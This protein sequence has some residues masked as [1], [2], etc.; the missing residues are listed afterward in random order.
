MDANAGV[1]PPRSSTPAANGIFV[2]LAVAFLLC[3]ALI[4]VQINDLAGL[5][6][7]PLL[8]HIP[9]ILVPILAVAAVA[10]MLRPDWRLRYGLALAILA[11]ISLASTVLTVGAGEAFRRARESAVAGLSGRLPQGIPAPPGGGQSGLNLHAQLGVQLRVIMFVFV[12]VILAIV[13]ADA[14]R[15]R[16]DHQGRLGRFAALVERPGLNR[17]IR[18]AVAGLAVLAV[19]WVVRTGHEG[20]KL[21]WGNQPGF[22]G[23]SQQ[24]FPPGQQFPGGGQQ[25]PGS[26]QGGGGGVPN[27]FGQ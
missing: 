18:V 11:L 13:I 25:A 26:G 15:G 24:Q 19:V 10:L 5:P 27:L 23:S 2:A 20:A 7:H 4:P 14:I 21:A 6:A 9:V 17:A 8:L 16:D 12:A 1:S 3:L 22:G